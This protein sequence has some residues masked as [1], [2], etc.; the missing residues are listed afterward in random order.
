MTPYSEP[1]LCITLEDDELPCLPCCGRIVVAERL[2]VRLKGPGATH[3][4]IVNAMVLARDLDDDPN[5]ATG[6]TRGLARAL[7]D[8]VLDLPPDARAWA[9]SPAALHAMSALRERGELP[10]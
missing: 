2:L 4:T 7:Y 9:D 10:S 5:G 8:A 3:T 1:C 6:A